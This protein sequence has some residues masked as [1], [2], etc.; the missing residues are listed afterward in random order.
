MFQ[1]ALFLFA[2]SLHLSSFLA[3]TDLFLKAIRFFVFCFLHLNLFTAVS[4]GL[5]HSA[6][7]M[8]SNHH[9]QYYNLEDFQLWELKYGLIVHFSTENLERKIKIVFFFSKLSL[10][11]FKKTSQNLFPLIVRILNTSDFPVSCYGQ[12]AVEM[13]R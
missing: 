13:G 10:Q 4:V 3:T 1:G 12:C 5:L 8:G 2:I 11:T 7:V 6:H 9:L